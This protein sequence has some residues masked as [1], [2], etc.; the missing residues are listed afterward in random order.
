ML[1]LKEKTITCL[2]WWMTCK[3]DWERAVND[4]KILHHLSHLGEH[5]I[6]KWRALIWF[7]L[8]SLELS[9]FNFLSAHLILLASCY[10]FQ[11]LIPNV[12]QGPFFLDFCFISLTCSPWLYYCFNQF[13]L[14]CWIT[15]VGSINTLLADWLPH[16][17]RHFK[18][19]SW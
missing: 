5:A 10:H 2:S 8:K 6:N 11:M 3:T 9:L 4:F 18:Y 17:W 1:E 7:K 14:F 12:N 16:W 19:T 13:T 15:F